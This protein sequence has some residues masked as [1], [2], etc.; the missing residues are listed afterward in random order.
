MMRV[1]AASLR[2]VRHVVKGES[3]SLIQVPLMIAVRKL[4]NRQNL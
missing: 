3:G 4:I 2:P 1:S